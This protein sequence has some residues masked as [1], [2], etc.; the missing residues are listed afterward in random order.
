G[1]G[2]TDIGIQPRVYRLAQASR[3]TLRLWR[4]GEALQ[5]WRRRLARLAAGGPWARGSVLAILGVAAHGRDI[6]RGAAPGQ[7]G[8]NDKKTPIGAAKLPDAKGRR[9]RA[10]AL[11]VRGEGIAMRASPLGRPGNDLLSR[12]LRRSTIGAGAFHGRVRN[13]IGCS[14]PAIITRSAKG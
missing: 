13:G 7:L 8:V 11:Q 2:G 14:H 9:W 3:R 6:G 12:V 5:R 10:A 1:R 4:A